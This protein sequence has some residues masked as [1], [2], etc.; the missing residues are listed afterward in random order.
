[1]FETIGYDA[2]EHAFVGYNVS[3]FAYGQTS[4]GKTYSMMGI[5][6]CDDVG[7]I[8]R[9]CRTIFHFVDLAADEYEVKMGAPVGCR[10]LPL[11]APPLALPLSLPSERPY[12]PGPPSLFTCD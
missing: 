12:L 5:P 1:V 4:S 8:P 3:I 10:S 7:L 6:A 9:I 11:S 2:V